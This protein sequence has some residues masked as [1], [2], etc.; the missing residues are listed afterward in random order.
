[1]I[2]LYTA[3]NRRFD[4]LFLSLYS[5]RSTWD[6][7]M[8]F[9]MLTICCTPVFK[10]FQFQYMHTTFLQYQ[11][12][13]LQFRD[14]KSCLL[15]LVVIYPTRY[16]SLNIGHLKFFYFLNLQNKKDFARKYSVLKSLEKKIPMV[17]RIYGHYRTI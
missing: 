7:I 15:V 10:K 3:H 17:C 12:N 8:F 1:M 13:V 6:D 16:C 2:A 11:N 14:E 9:I 4:R 5:L